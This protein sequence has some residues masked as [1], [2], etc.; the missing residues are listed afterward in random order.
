MVEITPS[1]DW[2]GGNRAFGLKI[3]EGA[4]SL[5]CKFA[6]HK[7]RFVEFLTAPEYMGEKLAA[8]SR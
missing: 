6:L 3:P 2:N 5:V 7:S 4:K 8:G 1:G